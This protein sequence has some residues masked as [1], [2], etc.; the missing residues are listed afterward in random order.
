MNRIDRISA[1]LVQ[2]QS[3]PVVKSSE[4]AERFGVSQRTIYRDMRTLSEAGVPICGN[5]GIG[6]SLVDGYRLP[7]LMFTKEEAMAFLTAEKIIEQL[8]DS[9]NSNY[10]RQGM[11]KVRAALKTVDKDYLHHMD[12]SIA[13][14]KSRNIRE[15]L[16]NLLQ[17]ILSS[18]NDRLI[19]EVDYINAQGNKSKRTLEAVGVSYSHPC[20][21]LSAWCHVREG[22]R[23]FRL[24]RING[25]KITT[26]SH[27]RVHPPL[28][29]LLG[30]D[31]SQ[32]L[33]EVVLHTS[34]E[35]ARY[36]ADR[37]FFMGLTDEKELPN[38]EIE[39]TYMAYSLELLARWTLA[40]ADTTTVVSP[41]EVK[42]IIKQIIKNLDL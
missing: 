23:A 12:N 21:Y 9:Q 32:C 38:G 30:V 14:Y 28:E 33:R 25:I 29:S 4:M 5:S 1:L 24:D 6:Y 15:S 27:T 19:T 42:D 26:D 22:Y 20:W 10:F 39:Q 40:N 35:V 17:T 11:D 37:C 3:R 13:V 8:T 7:S 16:P 41:V 36:N 34:K 31:D 2:L 18:I